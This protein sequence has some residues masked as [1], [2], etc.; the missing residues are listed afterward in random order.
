V[1]RFRWS[2]AGRT[3]GRAVKITAAGHRSTAGADPK[4][5]SAAT[6]SID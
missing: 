4:G 5:Y 2:R 6:C 3:V 1:V